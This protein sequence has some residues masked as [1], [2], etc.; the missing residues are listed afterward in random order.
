MCMDPSDGREPLWHPA[1]AGDGSEGAGPPEGLWWRQKVLRDGEQGW[2]DTVKALPAAGQPHLVQKHHRGFDDLAP[3]LQLRVVVFL[4][5]LQ[6]LG[7]LCL[8]LG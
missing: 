8:R 3:F 6:Q 5:G 2:E 4:L 7:P 1:P